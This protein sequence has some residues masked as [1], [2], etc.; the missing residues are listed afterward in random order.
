MDTIKYKK[1]V[2]DSCILIYACDQETKEECIKFLQQLIKNR[3]KIT[4]SSF[5]AFE[6]LK[7]RQR[8]ENEK[9]Y[10]DLLNDI[11]RIPVDSPT[12]ANAA[13][14]HFL[15][16]ESGRINKKKNLK[17]NLVDLKDKFTGDLIIGG[18]VISYDNHLLLTA[19]KKDFPEPYWKSIYE[20]EI[21]T[22]N[23]IKIKIYLLDPVMEEI[24]KKLEKEIVSPDDAPSRQNSY[25]YRG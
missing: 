9:E 18:T 11:Y 10:T 23:N 20:Y 16:E 14:L 21:K 7:N 3:N 19:N 6:V 12:L 13:T 2:L 5:S 1:I 8:R 22:A 25:E 4:Y 15:Y 24:E 17:E